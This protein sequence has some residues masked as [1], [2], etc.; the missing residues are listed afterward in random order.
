MR[1]VAQRVGRASVTVEESTI[2]SIGRGLLLLAGASVSDTADDVAAV[3]AK[4]V[5]LRVFPDDDGKINLSVGDIGGSVLLVSQF[6]LLGDVRKGRRPSFTDAAPPD[7]ARQL[8]ESLRAGIESYGIEVAT[9]VFGAHMIVDLSNDGPVT[10]LIETR[11]GRI[12]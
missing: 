11:E 9:G 10:V 6:T 2:S 5:G 12:V 8:L 1:V 7:S 4:I 3:A